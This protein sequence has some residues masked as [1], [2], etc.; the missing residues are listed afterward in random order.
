MIGGKGKEKS[1]VER[2][3]EL[4]AKLLLVST[5]RGAPAAPRGLSPLRPSPQNL[6]ACRPEALIEGEGLLDPEAAHNRN[7]RRI[8]VKSWA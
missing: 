2:L 7:G 4:E 5:R 8:L 3:Q 1:I 6:K